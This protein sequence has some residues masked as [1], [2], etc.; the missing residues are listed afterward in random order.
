MYIEQ[1]FEQLPCKKL[2]HFVQKFGKICKNLAQMYV[3][4]PNAELGTYIC[5]V[6]R[7]NKCFAR[8]CKINSVD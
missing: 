7:M 2:A 1:T 3:E 4:K 6:C 8:L 5:T